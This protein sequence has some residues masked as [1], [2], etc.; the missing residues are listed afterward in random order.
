M[1]SM[2]AIILLSALNF[3]LSQRQIDDIL[4]VKGQ[5]DCGLVCNPLF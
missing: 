5:C 3:P 4:D 2:V 1:I